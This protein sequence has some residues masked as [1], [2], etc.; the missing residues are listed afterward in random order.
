M[1][2]TLLF[3]LDGTLIDSNADIA[4][5][6]NHVRGQYGLPP[7]SLTEVTAAIGDGLHKL[8]ERTVPQADARAA[9]LYRAH[10]AEHLLD[11]TVLYSGVR[12][13]LEQLQQARVALA[14]VSNKP[15]AFCERVLEGL[16]VRT[17]FA[18]VVG[19]DSAAGRKPDPGPVRQALDLVGRTSWD[20]LMVGD[21]PGDI[22]AG[23]AA[24]VGTVAALWGF[25]SAEQL[26]ASQPD[27]T[28]R[29]F[30]EVVAMVPMDGGR[31]RSVFEALGR[32][33]LFALA[34]AFYQRVPDEPRL[35]G[36][37]P[38]DLREPIERQALFLIQFFGGPPDYAIRRGAPRLRMRHGPFRI[39]PEQA[40]AWLDLMLSAMQ[41]IGIEEPA[42]G[43]MRRYFAHTAAFLINTR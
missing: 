31:V 38:F 4:Q 8:L 26:A 36:M 25:R 24:N 14:V 35:S 27:T 7:L 18:A 30:A 17:F 5:S 9:D 2:H 21:S 42:A 15:T 20:A 40:Q 10:H 11:H 13:G 34:R 33:R 23:R 22:A 29:S 41:E 28:A 32:D 6:V 39:G 19:G 3:D 37:F 16:G 12:A 43:V 1:I